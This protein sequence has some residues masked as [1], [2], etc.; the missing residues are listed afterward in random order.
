VLAFLYRYSSMHNRSNIA[1]LAPIVLPGVENV[2]LGDM[3]VGHHSYGT[4]LL[5]L[6]SVVELGEVSRFAGAKYQ[7]AV[8]VEEAQPAHNLD[9]VQ[10]VATICEVEQSVAKEAL[11]QF[12]GQK[13][14]AIFAL[15]Q[16]KGLPAQRQVIRRT[17]SDTPEDPQ[18]RAVPSIEETMMFDSNIGGVKKMKGESK[19]IPPS[20]CSS[21]AETDEPQIRDVPQNTGQ[22]EYIQDLA[23]LPEQ[24]TQSPEE[25][26]DRDPLPSGGAVIYEGNA[27]SDLRE[28]SFQPSYLQPAEGLRTSRERVFTNEDHSSDASSEEDDNDA[29]GSDQEWGTMVDA[30]DPARYRHKYKTPKITQ[31]KSSV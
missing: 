7:G 9:P 22:S 26:Q 11:M 29:I 1:G 12:K 6:A 3:I 10:E 15:L 28:S 13:E 8:L 17:S 23:E 4:E 31:G 19:V 14:D 2:P 21:Q 27:T 30:E 18:S 24:A 20:P 16:S 25:V 5:R